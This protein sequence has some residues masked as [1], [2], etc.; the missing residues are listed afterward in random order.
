MN[1]PDVHGPATSTLHSTS[2]DMYKTLD[3]FLGHWSWESDAT[4][5]TLDALTNASLAQESHAGGRTVGRIAWHIAQTIPEMMARTGLEVKGVGEH[6]PVPANAADVA[7]GYR[8][9]AASLVDQIKSRWTDDTLRESDDMYGERWTRSQTLM[10]LTSHQNHHR[11][12]L[13]VL[14][15]QAGLPVPAIYGP[16]KEDWSK[17]N[18]APPAI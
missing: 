17:M 9:A 16:T 14:M 4:Q 11:G 7:S 6:D 10:A 15:R 2:R 8:A 12:Q 13:T 3:D 1:E 18:M 5:K